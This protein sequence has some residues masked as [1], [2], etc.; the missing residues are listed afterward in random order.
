M[1]GG[2]AYEALNNIGHSQRRVIVVLNDN[3]RSYAPTVSNLTA[4]APPPA[5][6]GASA[7][8]QP[9]RR[10]AVP[11][12]HRDPPQPDVRPPPAPPRGA[13][14]RRP[15]RRDTGR[16]GRRRRQGGGA[17]GA[18][19]AGVLRGPRRAL[20]RT[21]STATTSRRSSRRSTTRSSSSEDGPILVHVITQKGRGYPPAEDDDE[22]HLHDAPVF[23]P[24]VGPPKAVP[25]GY[26]QAFAEAVIK[27]AEADARHRR[28]HGGDGRADGSAAVPVALPGPLLRRRHRRA[29]RRHRAPPA[30]RWAA[31]VRSSPSTRR[32]STEPGTRSSTTSPCTAC[33]SCSASTAPAITGPDGPSHHGVYDMALLARVPGHA[34]ARAVERPGAAAD[35]HRRDGARRRRPGRHPLP[36]WPGAQRGRARGRR[37]HPGPPR[38][39]P[40]T[41]RRRPCASSPSASSSRP[42]RRPPTRSCAAGVDVTVWDVRCCAPLDTDMLA[43]AARHR[44]VVTCEDGVRDG[45][46]GMAI[47]DRLGAID[48]AVPVEVLGTPTRFLPH[49][50]RPGADPRPARSRRRRNPGRRPPV[51]L[52]RCL[53]APP[54]G[55]R[56]LHRQLRPHVR[57][58]AGRHH[59]ARPTRR[60]ARLPALLGRRAPQHEHRRQHVAARADGPPRRVDVVDPHRLRRA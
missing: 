8:D 27:E 41:T 42:P 45:G 11:A 34:G 18:P 46:I 6:P 19:A 16:E 29:A 17:R 55:P 15:R 33:R 37:R 23:D 38:A 30:W 14:A 25:T 43:D 3:G 50:G 56:P 2:M 36:A 53:R 59:D 47:E 22:K 54:L 52:G 60:G 13:A 10:P 26:T 12:A 20:R 4:Y 39:A 44:A 1:T 57:R 48:P 7:P 49:D 28:H 51:P 40:R 9:H 5:R 24:V 58:G 21:R 35:A 31:S 32:S